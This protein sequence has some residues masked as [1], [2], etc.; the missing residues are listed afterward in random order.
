[1]EYP[2]SGKTRFLWLIHLIDL[3][4]RHSDLRKG[5]PV[6]I[7]FSAHLHNEKERQ[8]ALFGDLNSSKSQSVYGIQH[9]AQTIDDFVNLVLCD[10]QGW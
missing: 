5:T 1:M 10:D 3:C 2:L 8:T 9:F 7:W 4:P 6:S